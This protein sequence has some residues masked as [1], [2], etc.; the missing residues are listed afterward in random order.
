[1]QQKIELKFLHVKAVVRVR[2]T[3]IGYQAT[4]RFP[5]AYIEARFNNYVIDEIA[6]TSLEYAVEIALFT[7][8]ERY[9][10]LNMLPRLIRDALFFVHRAVF[11]IYRYKIFE[12]ERFGF[13][14]NCQ[15]YAISE[16]V[17]G[18]KWFKSKFQRRE[19]L[20]TRETLLLINFE[21]IFSPMHNHGFTYKFI[22]RVLNRYDITP[23]SALKLYND[24]II[25]LI[26]QGFVFE[27]HIAMNVKAESLQNLIYLHKIIKGAKGPHIP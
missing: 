1:M 17:D 15:T 19:D 13:L 16:N 4:I 12:D 10:F 6:A 11:Q 26:P 14:M 8:K 24:P 22:E 20:T 3:G 18:K 5:Y 25:Y 2:S 27:D 9:N 21:K 23:L 7:F